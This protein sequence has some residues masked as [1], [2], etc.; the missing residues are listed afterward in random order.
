MNFQE[1]NLKDLGD[2][3]AQLNTANAKVDLLEAQLA[4]AKKTGTSCQW[5]QFRP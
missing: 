4:D 2:L 1:V 5:K 3:A